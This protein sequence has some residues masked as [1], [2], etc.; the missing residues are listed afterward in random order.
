MERNEDNFPTSRPVL[1]CTSLVLHGL[2]FGFCEFV[3]PKINQQASARPGSTRLYLKYEAAA[4]LRAILRVANKMTLA[5]SKPTAY[6]LD[7]ASER[8]RAL[9]EETKAGLLTFDNSPSSC[10]Y[11][12]EST[13]SAKEEQ[14]KES[15]DEA[16]AEMECN[17]EPHGQE[18]YT[19]FSQQVFNSQSKM[20]DFK[21]LEYG[22]QTNEPCFEEQKQ[23][24][25]GDLTTKKDPSSPDNE[26]NPQSPTHQPY[27][28]N[29]DLDDEKMPTSLWMIETL[30]QQGSL[31]EY[32]HQ[33]QNTV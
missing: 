11:G 17:L 23:L 28:Y 21:T 30:I 9:E 15:N 5:R 14:C 19:F 26:A 7:A 29:Q 20:L 3:M 32:L 6:L 10:N 2:A 22:V 4:S 8:L 33:S 1:Y 24:A 31:L 18:T 16:C 27:G 25:C 13:K 12:L